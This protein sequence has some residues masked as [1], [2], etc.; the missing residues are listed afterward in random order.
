MTDLSAENRERLIDAR[1]QI[2]AIRENLHA[3]VDPA[4]ISIKA[5]TPYKV[6]VFRETLL[7]RT[8]ELGRCCCD[9]YER[10]DY[11]CALVATRAVMENMA[12]MVYLAD[13]LASQLERGLSSDADDRVMA[14]LMGHRN[15]DEMPNAVNVLTMLGKAE[16]LV[17]QISEIYASLS[18][19]AHPN[20]SGTSGLFAQLDRENILT[21]LSRYPRGSDVP[22][23]TGTIALA[24]A[25]ELLV[26]A[27]DKVGERLSNFV[28]LCE[29]ALSVPPSVDA[30]VR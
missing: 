4:N 13:L 8:E 10:G 17:P 24:S 23:T 28:D 1:R 3:A 18:E 7:W 9:L 22:V 16:K 21:N 29:A 2:V 20:W 26:Y 11:C 27:Y 6:I 15:W 19:Y 14:L 30:K 5:K 12:A 25:L